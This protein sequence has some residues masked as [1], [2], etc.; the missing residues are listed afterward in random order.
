MILRADNADLRLT[1][2]G[3]NIGLISEERKH[4]FNEKKENLDKLTKTMDNIKISPSK[5]KKYGI[6]IAKD[7]ILRS[8]NQV[9]SRK[10]VNMKKIREIW[11][12]IP[13]YFIK[14][15]KSK[16]INI[17]DLNPGTGSKNIRLE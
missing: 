6:N 3:I 2:K 7:G 1:K 9:L 15:V 8:A 14:E 11:E 4:I 13:V 16:F 17:K 10:G 5:I 12:K